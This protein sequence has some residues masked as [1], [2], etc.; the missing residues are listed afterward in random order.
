MKLI[1]SI[2]YSKITG[3]VYEIVASRPVSNG[4]YNLFKYTLSNDNRR[5][6]ICVWGEKIAEREEMVK[7]RSVI[8]IDGA[9]CKR[10]S[11]SYW[12]Q[13]NNLVPNEL[14]V[15]THT[16][17]SVLGVY[18]SSDVA[19]PPQPGLALNVTFDT[20]SNVDDGTLIGN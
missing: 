13:G 19:E 16:L 14:H 7:M 1:F 12:R 17:A 5:V 11:Q 3:Y 2:F 10:T 18:P 6:Q 20:I 15:Q 9:L 8:H 4:R